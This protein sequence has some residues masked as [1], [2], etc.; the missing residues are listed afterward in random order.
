MSHEPIEPLKFQPTK[1]IV[2]EKTEHIICTC[3]S[4]SPEGIIQCP[5]CQKFHHLKC[6]R[7]ALCHDCSEKEKKKP[8][9]AR[10][11]ERDMKTLTRLAK[12]KMEGDSFNVRM[13]KWDHIEVDD[14]DDEADEDFDPK[15]GLNK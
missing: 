4:H 11:S 3:G 8:W 2:L 15:K 10:E 9:L 6:R 1:V 12:K 13:A 5:E 7:K 14:D